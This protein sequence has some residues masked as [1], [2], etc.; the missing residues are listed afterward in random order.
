MD[1]LGLCPRP[2]SLSTGGWQS[3]ESVAEAA[4]A[5]ITGGA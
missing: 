3:M 5:S 2:G 1:D 4:A